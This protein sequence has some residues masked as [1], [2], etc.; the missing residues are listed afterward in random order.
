MANS[1]IRR[2]VLR[3]SCWDSKWAGVPRAALSQKN[4]E[5]RDSR[6]A[7]PSVPRHDGLRPVQSP[8][9]QE[10]RLNGGPASRPECRRFA[11]R[12]PDRAAQTAES[13]SPS[14]KGANPASDGST[15]RMRHR[16]R[17][18]NL[19]AP[20]QEIAIEASGRAPSLR[21]LVIQN[22]WGQRAI[23]AS[24]TREICPKMVGDLAFA[25]AEPHTSTFLLRN[26]VRA[27]WVKRIVGP[28]APHRR[29]PSRFSSVITYH[30]FSIHAA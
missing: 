18:L 23:C 4:R 13:T 10:D 20:R 9:F 28:V 22:P 12:A 17:L 30:R 29:S 25:C 14:T 26:R 7:N 27:V 11:P 5:L 3:Q 21:R 19:T 6:K 1:P 15:L 16:L 8:W 24:R 2:P